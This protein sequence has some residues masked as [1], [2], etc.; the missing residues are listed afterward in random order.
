MTIGEVNG[1]IE[2]KT[3]HAVGFWM[4]LQKYISKDQGNLL[5][6]HELLGVGSESTAEPIAANK[7]AYSR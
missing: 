4:T 2:T 1:I 7:A 6:Q 5:R 3:H